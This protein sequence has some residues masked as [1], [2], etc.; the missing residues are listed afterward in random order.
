MKLSF[1]VLGVLIF[2][3][4]SITSCNSGEVKKTGK[5]PDNQFPKDTAEVFAEGLLSTEMNDR[6][7]TI[8]PD[9]LE[10]FFTVAEGPHY[11]IA[12]VKK[13]NGSWSNP[14]IAGFSGKYNDVEPMF[15]PDGNR[16]YFCSNRPLSD[17]GKVKDW[18]IWYVEKSSNG[19]GDPVNIGAPVNTERHEFYPSVARNGN[20]Y[21][22]SFDNRIMFAQWNGTT[23]DEPVPVSDSINSRRAEYNAFVAPDESYILF[24]SHGWKQTGGRGDIFISKRKADK[25]WATPMCISAISEADVEM[26]P[27]VSP[28]GKY[29]FFSRNHRKI[30]FDISIIN[31]ESIRKHNQQSQN[32]KFDIYWI[33]SD[34]LNK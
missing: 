14:E 2:S 21:F 1:Y 32:G 9:F 5:Y 25:S 33:S 16:L 4:T 30:D 7:I 8:S 20:M 13:E 17:T 27:F 31:Y 15:S 29:L 23:Y 18:D 12:S 26:C 3:A 11:T 19:W 10:I 28:D 34:V 24:T 6:D 22:T